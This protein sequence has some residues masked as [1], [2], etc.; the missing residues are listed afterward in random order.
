MIEHWNKVWQCAALSGYCIFWDSDR[1]VQGNGGKMIS[2]EE[3][4]NLEKK[5]LLY[6]F[7]H[8][9]SYLKLPRT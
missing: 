2:R 4:K 8:H 7:I 9:E 1:W 5:L 3:L 6:Q